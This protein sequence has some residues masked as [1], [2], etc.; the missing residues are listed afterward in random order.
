MAL[1][2]SILWPGGVV[3]SNC[4]QE[5][6]VEPDHHPGPR[7]KSRGGPI[8]YRQH[9]VD[10]LSTSY[11]CYSKL[12]VNHKLDILSHLSPIYFNQA[13]MHNAT[14][15]EVDCALFIGVGKQPTS[16]LD[17]FNRAKNLEILQCEYRRR[18]QPLEGKTKDIRMIWGGAGIRQRRRRR[19]V[20]GLS[21]PR[22]DN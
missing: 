16:K 12:S 13:Y 19:D 14:M 2:P 15:E 11:T 3:S 22:N 18:N 7:R 1:A 8:R 20:A 10:S 21:E 17:S 6:D 5:E 4:V 9:K